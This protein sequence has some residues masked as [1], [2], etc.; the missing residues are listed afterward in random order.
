MSI[1]RVS[2]LKGAVYGVQPNGSFVH[3]AYDRDTGLG[4]T[5]KLNRPDRPAD[6]GDLSNLLTRLVTPAIKDLGDQPVV[7]MIHGFLFDPRDSVSGTP[8]ESDN[9]HSRL[10]HFHARPGNE[11]R[12]HT[13]GWPVHLGFDAADTTGKSGLAFAFGWHSRPGFASSL[14][15]HFQNFYARA[16]ENAEQAAWNL[17]CCLDALHRLLPKNKRIDLFCHS[18]GSRVV[19][20][21]IAQMAKHGQ[22]DVLKRIDRTIILGGAEYVVE[23]RLMLDRLGGAGMRKHIQFYNVVSRENDVL[24]ML[25]ENFGPRTFGNSNVIGHNGLDVEEPDRSG[26]TWLDL[27]IDGGKL[28]RWLKRNRK[29]IVC[30]DNPESIWDHWYYYTHHGNMELYRS[31]LRNRDDW[32]ITNLRKG[33]KGVRIPDKVSRRRSI[34][35][36]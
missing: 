16:Y 20:R 34:F 25:G 24:D 32:I 8:A 33:K 1:V 26:S 36:D 13:T 22:T 5:E 6:D 10:Y 11:V 7:V 9:P 4:R 23:A 29:I 21:A 15:S 14:I 30:G 18:L 12:E 28:A 35:G 31:I 17:A 19:V 3:G 2:C 27:Q